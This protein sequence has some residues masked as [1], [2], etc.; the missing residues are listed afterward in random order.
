MTTNS[1]SPVDE[2][3]DSGSGRSAE[4]FI[5]KDDS[6]AS[7]LLNHGVKVRDLILLSF[8]SDKGPMSVLQLSRMVGLE[9]ADTLRG[10]KRLSAANLALRDPSPMNGELESISRLTGRGEHIAARISGQIV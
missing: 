5:T 3:A 2:P 7:L 10:L 4:Y 9:P 1:K 6:L 8:L